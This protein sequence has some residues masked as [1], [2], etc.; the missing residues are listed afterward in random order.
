M[1]NDHSMKIPVCRSF[2]EHSIGTFNCDK[3]LA[4]PKIRKS[5]MRSGGAV[6]V[7]ETAQDR[8]SRLNAPQHGII[9]FSSQ[10]IQDAVA[11]R[12]KQLAQ[13]EQ[14]NQI[15]EMINEQNRQDQIRKTEL[16]KEIGHQK[17]NFV[18]LFSGAVGGLNQDFNELSVEEL[19]QVLNHKNKTVENQNKPWYEKAK[20]VFET[21]VLPALGDVANIVGK[22]IPGA[23]AITDKIEDVT[24]HGVHS[25]DD[26]GPFTYL[27]EA[28]PALASK[29]IPAGAAKDI[30]SAY[31]ASKKLSLLGGRINPYA[32]HYRKRKILHKSKYS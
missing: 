16:I 2:F 1:Q 11:Q 5:K 22:V 7:R 13:Q 18:N 29:F 8:E 27:I 17:S 21:A 4:M 28:A 12:G 31:D 6:N 24:N 20:S 14:I 23:S 30:L 19:E 3:F 25:W 9:G 15:L 26:L 10:Q 32:A